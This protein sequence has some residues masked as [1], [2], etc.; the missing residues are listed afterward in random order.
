MATRK[1]G[2]K[3]D[4]SG[5]MKADDMATMLQQYERMA[6]GD[7]EFEMDTGLTE[8]DD[9]DIAQQLAAMEAETKNSSGMPM[10]T[11]AVSGSASLDVETDLLGLLD[12]P[13]Q[14][15]ARMEEG[16]RPTPAPEA[17][18]LSAELTEAS[19]AIEGKA[20]SAQVRFTPALDVYPTAQP[21][22]LILLFVSHADSRGCREGCSVYP[23]CA[24]LPGARSE[25][26]SVHHGLV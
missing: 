23:P 4:R 5:L 21:V 16:P 7:F 10:Q 11:S 25:P 14:R 19:A 26:S 8:D 13:P 15:R 22:V 18:A 17:L 24:R 12:E 3:L 1:D 9:A 2:A 6:K 20:Q